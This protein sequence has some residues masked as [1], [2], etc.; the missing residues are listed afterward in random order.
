MDNCYSC[1]VPFDK[2]NN[3][4][5]HIINNSI[6]GK[7]RSRSLLCK[8]CN[9]GFGSG[10]DQ[11]L[12]KQL[13]ILVDHLG[14]NRQRERKNIAI[15]MKAS[16]GSIKMVAKQLK[17]LARLTTSF[18][19]GKKVVEF[20]PEEEFNKRVAEKKA[21]LSKKYKTIN[22]VYYTELPGKELYTIKNSL[23]DEEVDIGFGG[24]E[25]YQ[26]ITKMAV[27]YY[28]KQSYDVQWVGEAIR[29][30][31]GEIANDLTFYYY[32]NPIHY[33]VHE[34]EEYEVSHIIHIRGIPEKGYLYAYVELFNMQN[35]LIRL[36]MNYSGP[37]INDTYSF[38]LLKG[39]EIEKQINVKLTKPH[40]KI[41]HLIT[42]ENRNE[43]RLRYR[44]LELII[45]NN[46][47]I[48]K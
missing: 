33:A 8:G 10:I 24:D 45:Q 18:P 40:F 41:L 14:V 17:P 35:V 42:K 13:G 28:L 12:N 47:L 1:G 6:G 30:I 5:E 2:T 46:Q 32:P 19:D 37:E 3:S 39:R 7:L 34:F 29:M 26:S 25:Y 38:D 43:I 48:K 4:Q 36:N 22:E 44:R 11:V 20:V 16:D 15:P 21:E 23:S 9:E 27:N 31:K